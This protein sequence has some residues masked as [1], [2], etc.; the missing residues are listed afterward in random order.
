[1]KVILAVAI[2]AVVATVALLAMC[3]TTDIGVTT[4][5][6][7]IGISTPVTVR[8]TNPHGVRRVRATWSR[9]GRA[10]R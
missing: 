6:K 7:T 1:M 3:T 8:L 2:L 10:I 4:A 9:T 5:V